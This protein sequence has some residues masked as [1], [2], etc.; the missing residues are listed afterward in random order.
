MKKNIGSVLALYP[1]PLT[2]IGSEGEDGKINWMLAG[3]VGIIG[4][5]KIMVSMHKAHFSNRGIRANKILSVNLVDEN[6]LPAA[7]YVG[8]VSALKVDKSSVFAWHRENNGA[9]VIEEAPLSMVCRVVD[10]YE[11]ETF[12]NFICTIESTLVAEDALTP[13]GKIDYGRLK[14]VLF[15]MPTYSYL[16]TGE[17]IGKCLD[18]AKEYKNKEEK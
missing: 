4:H 13:Q 7:D 10:N 3:H 8:S 2:V 6:L 17:V 9:P 11:T 12:D 14:P 15:E 16:K 5:D 1:M 18:F